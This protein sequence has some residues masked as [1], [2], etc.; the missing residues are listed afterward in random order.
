MKL[1]EIPTREAERLD[2]LRSLNMLDTEPEP[3]FE[4]I[5]DL[6]EAV[7]EVPRVFIS[8]VDTDRMWWKAKRGV[9]DMPQAPRDIGFCS[10]SINEAECMVVEDAT[11][12]ERFADNPF[13][14]GDFNL[15]FYAGSVVHGPS[16]EPIGS[17][18][19]VDTKP[20]HFSRHNQEVLERFA[21]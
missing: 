2:D 4:A 13:V 16:G 6:A 14:T 21:A 10:H 9:G 8:L 18:A 1:A 15:R 5:V 3:R 20:R 17:F 7:F 12:D 11:K 19:I